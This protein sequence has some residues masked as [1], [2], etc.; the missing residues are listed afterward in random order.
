MNESG[1]PITVSSSD[2]LHEIPIC[3]YFQKSDGSNSTRKKTFECPK[4]RLRKYKTNEVLVGEAKCFGCEGVIIA[5]R[6]EN[7][8]TFLGDLQDMTTH[9]PQPVIPEEPV[10]MSVDETNEFSIPLTEVGIALPS[11]PEHKVFFNTRRYYVT[12]FDIS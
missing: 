6:N 8:L 5:M 10:E 4:C 7:T 2:D 9:K 3:R 11:E 1:E 12:C